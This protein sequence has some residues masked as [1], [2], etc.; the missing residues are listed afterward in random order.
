M[1]VLRDAPLGFLDAMELK[2]QCS[3]GSKYKFDV[4]PVDGRVPAPLSCPNC[5]ASWTEHANAMIAQTLGLP[6]PVAPAVRVAVAPAM[7]ASSV[8]APAKVVLRI[9]GH[10]ATADP[11]VPA[12]A[13]EPASAAPPTSPARHMPYVPTI[14]PVVDEY[15]SGDFGRGFLGA[16]VGA[17][18]GGIAYYLL[19]VHTDVRLKLIGLGVGVLAGFGAR[20]FGKDRSKELGVIAAVLSIVMIVGAQY[21]AV[22][23]WANEGEL[24]ED[25]T[26]APKSDYDERVAEAKRVMEAI[27]KGTDQ[28]I[29][30]Y[31][32]K[33]MVE[34]GEKPDPKSIG[35]GEIQEFKEESLPHYRKLADRTYTKEQYDK[36]HTV[37]LT[38]EEKQE[39]KK[40]DERVM[41]WV[42]LAF[43]M[44][45]FNLVCIA[46]AA[47]IS[48]K[49]IANA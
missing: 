22:L 4:E 5:Q 20:L 32:A 12:S 3:C 43:L 17:L 11:V 40:E 13:P 8:S 1:T 18:F 39:M 42:F 2:I 47:G 25:A 16:A 19:F 33:E 36:D 31:L 28:E 29:R 7:P 38:A 45:K 26:E 14:A 35:V 10:T 23:H 44:Q 9:G 41:K 34:E 15:K 30:L 21:L 27:P 46:G 49:I 37:T 24:S 6:V 48:Y